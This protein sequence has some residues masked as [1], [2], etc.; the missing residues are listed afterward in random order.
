MIIADSF[1]QQG[2]GH[3]VCEDYARHGENYAV[4]SDGCSNGDGPRIDSDWGARF[5]CRAGERAIWMQ[6][7]PVHYMQLLGQQLKWLPSALEIPNE[8]LTATLM[9]LCGTSLRHEARAIGDGV[10]GG[11]RFDGRW[12]IYVIEFPKGPYYLKYTLFGEESSFQKKFTE[13]YKVTTYF[14]KL[15]SPEM[16]LKGETYA[17]RSEKWSQT[18]SMSWKEHEV[19]FKF[20]WHDFMFSAEDYDLVFIASDGVESFE[21]LRSTPTGKHKEQVHLLDV[22]RVLLD[23]MVI[24]P[25]FA[26]HQRHWA[27]KQNKRGTFPCRNWKNFDD[28]S[29][30][31]LARDPASSQA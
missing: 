30:G 8:F 12:K 2:A 31:V 26:Q 29:M 28:V 18:M 10:I 11:R 6:D 21:E 27:F 13:F 16:E 23:F 1:F 9:T 3:D 22:L 19:D 7:H 15:M 24:K 5:L 17:E 25:G 14:G 4:I 20:P